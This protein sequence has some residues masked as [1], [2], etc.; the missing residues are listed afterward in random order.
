LSHQK[1]VLSRGAASK[2]RITIV[3]LSCVQEVV[4]EF[5]KFWEEGEMAGFQN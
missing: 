1:N 5:S 3:L 2:K 4:E